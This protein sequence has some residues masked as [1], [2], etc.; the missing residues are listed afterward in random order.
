[1]KIENLNSIIDSVKS[2]KEYRGQLISTDI[3]VSQ[4]NPV[5]SL[6]ELKSNKRFS[7][8]LFS[9]F[10]RLDQTEFVKDEIEIVEKIISGEDVLVVSVS[11][12]YIS[13]AIDCSIIIKSFYQGEKILLI[14]KEKKETILA[15]F[16]S[17]FDGLIEFHQLSMSS[18]FESIHSDITVIHPS[19]LIY[20]NETKIENRYPNSIMVDCVIIENIQMYDSRELNHLTEIIK[21]FRKIRYQYGLKSEEINIIT[22]STPIENRKEIA[23][24]FAHK[25]NDAM[26]TI[27]I[28][29]KTNSFQFYFWKP[30]L[31]TESKIEAFDKIYITKNSLVKDIQ[32]ILKSILISQENVK[33]LLWINEIGLSNDFN[34]NL[35]REI[36][37][38]I[39]NN[40]DIFTSNIRTISRIENLKSSEYYS[41]DIVIVINPSKIS[42]FLLEQCGKI[43]N[44]DNGMVILFS[45]EDHLSHQLIRSRK[46]SL[47]YDH[48][49][50][51][52][53]KLFVLNSIKIQD[54]Y[55]KYFTKEINTFNDLYFA[56]SE[57]TISGKLK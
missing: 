35:F 51:N 43:V 24:E 25:M 8:L 44:D 6:S 50:F 56:E 5:I 48:E 40:E 2:S 26:I 45:G 39:N 9:F 19:E 41:F 34:L 42:G 31:E 29:T 3:N 11:D 33:I 16:Q 7:D 13:F 28:D 21:N 15:R 22:T 12:P 27:P 14:S 18:F 20:V 32:S 23:N 10:S 53:P 46:Y 30:S 47:V 55:K 17:Y 38:Y 37:N 49:K 4:R 57:F 1:M 52:L 54:F 36:N